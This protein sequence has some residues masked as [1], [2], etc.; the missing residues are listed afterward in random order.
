MLINLNGLVGSDEF[1]IK[2]YGIIYSD[3]NFSI[4][5]QRLKYSFSYQ[6]DIPIDFFRDLKDFIDWNQLSEYYLDFSNDFILEFS[7]K[8]NWDICRKQIYFSQEK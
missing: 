7:D 2:Y 4:Y 8:L 1:R 6:Q 5:P 3:N